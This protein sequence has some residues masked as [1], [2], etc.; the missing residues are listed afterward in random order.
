MPVVTLG[1]GSALQLDPA[2]ALRV[3]CACAKSAMH[4]CRDAAEAVTAA[5]WATRAMALGRECAGRRVTRAEA[6]RTGGLD[7]A[8][9]CA[10]TMVC[11]L[12]AG[13]VAAREGC[14][15]VFAMY[16]GERVDVARALRRAC[17]EAHGGA[18][19][20]GVPVFGARKGSGEEVDVSDYLSV[21]A[22]ASEGWEGDAEHAVG[23]LELFARAWFDAA[24]NRTSTPPTARDAQNACAVLLNA[25]RAVHAIVLSK[26]DGAPV[27]LTSFSELFEPLREFLHYVALDD[28]IDDYFDEGIVGELTLKRVIVLVCEVTS[29]VVRSYAACETLQVDQPMAYALSSLLE[30]VELFTADTN[31]FYEIGELLRNDLCDIFNAPPETFNRTWLPLGEVGSRVVRQIRGGNRSSHSLSLYQIVGNLHD[32]E[33]DGAQSELSR[34]IKRAKGFS[35][36]AC[37][38]NIRNLA[39]AVR[40]VGGM[41]QP[42]EEEIENYSRFVSAME[43]DATM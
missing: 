22:V 12:A 40:S 9:A 27:D 6:A 36:D 25:M 31:A 14:G 35:R 28:A 29:E 41:K 2:V 7:E 1:H 20:P 30:I 21:I 34:S 10:R 32:V 15:G 19:E 13:A 26:G 17:V 33:E 5:A 16:V 3:A 38:E 8:A 11:M 43:T 23:C 37:L 39:V 24:S 42:T 4:E 18:R